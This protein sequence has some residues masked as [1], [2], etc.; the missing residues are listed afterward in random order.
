MFWDVEAAGRQGKRREERWEGTEGDEGDAKPGS[1][2]RARG[3]RGASAQPGRRSAWAGG[4][5]RRRRV[6]GP[7]PPALTH[8][9][10]K[11]QAVPQRRHGRHGA[12]HLPA[13]PRLRQARAPANHCVSLTPRANYSSE[14]GL[15]TDFG[16]Q[17]ARERIQNPRTATDNEPTAGLWETESA[18]G[19]AEARAKP[20]QVTKRKKGCGRKCL[21]VRLLGAGRGRT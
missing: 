4:E 6:V 8:P 20:D 2:R 16:E 12:G 18:S 11:A 14:E 1:S 21:P 10:Q 9:V 7:G 3:S 15:E 19:E 17:F 5:A 13:P